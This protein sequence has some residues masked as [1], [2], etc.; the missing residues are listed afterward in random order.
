[1][2]TILSALSLILA[3]VLPFGAHAAELRPLQAGTF[4]LG[5]HTVSIHYTAT[6]GIYEVVTTIAAPTGAPIRF[7]GFLQ[8][9]QKALVSA[10]EFGATTDPETLEL[11]HQGDFLSVAAVTKI[12][13]V[14]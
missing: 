8:P 5:A 13:T 2:K 6:N 3:T 7:V 10:G 9:G 4:G 11:V 14:Q 12:A 1:M